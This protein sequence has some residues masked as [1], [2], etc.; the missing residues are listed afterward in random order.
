M[1][2]LEVPAQ[3]AKAQE[4]VKDRETELQGVHKRATETTKVKCG[5]GVGP[6]DGGHSVIL[7]CAYGFN[8]GGDVYEWGGREY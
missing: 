6:K 2:S 3:A 8:S 1:V 4:S 5:T 7:S